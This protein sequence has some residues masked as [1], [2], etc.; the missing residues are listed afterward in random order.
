MTRP[1][2]HTNCVKG[3]D[4]SVSSR[5]DDLKTSRAHRSWLQLNKGVTLAGLVMAA[6]NPAFAQGVEQ[7]SAPAAPTSAQADAP[8]RE[9][10][11]TQ[12]LALMVENGLV[13]QAQADALLNKAR[14]SQAQRPQVVA[15]STEPGVQTVPYIPETVRRQLRDEV[16]TEVMT[17]ARTEGWAQP[18]QMPEWTRR[19]T[20]SGDVRVRGEGVLFPDEEL[21]SPGANFTEFP[22]FPSINAGSGLDLGTSG[23]NPPFLNVTEDRNRARIRARLNADIAIDDGISAKLR[24]ATGSD[25]SPVSTNQT[26]GGNGGGKYAIWLDRAS[27]QFTPIKQVTLDFGR[28]ENPF[29]TSDLLF[30]TDMNFDGLAAR[31]RQKLGAGAT[32]FGTIGAFPIF[33]TNFNFSDNDVG[34]FGSDD[35]YLAALQAGLIWESGDDVKLTAAVG[36]FNFINVDGKVSSP[37]A[38]TQAVCDTDNT[39]PAFAQFGNSYF[40]I[41]NISPEPL[42]REVQYFGLAS[43]FEVVNAHAQV[44]IGVI[45]AMP[46]RLEA[47]YV[48]NLAFD[49]DVMVARGLVNP[50]AGGPLDIG[51]EGW[52]VNATVGDQSVKAFGDWNL[53]LGYRY[54]ESDAVLDA[55][56]D[57]DFHLGGTNAEG[58]TVGATFGVGRNTSIGGRMLSANEVSGPPLSVDVVQFDLS[59]RF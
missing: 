24:L 3:N 7:P 27:I 50:R 36:Y 56:T 13:T 39:R 21:S 54:L 10:S 34:A 35:K 2:R 11:A 18:G 30:D 40:P 53:Q 32:A 23:P 57:S 37:C 55:F 1:G 46:I 12:L 42:T 45:S 31:G 52:L 4:M 59:T 5:K 16:R 25:S 29:W 48:R 6:A 43:R 19:I 38:E 9:I 8:G 28:F 41:R 15:Q 33:N 49:E 44:D 47:D 14:E 22:N 17:Q 20:L 51:D 26:L 58:F